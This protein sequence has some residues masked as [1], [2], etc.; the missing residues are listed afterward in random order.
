MFTAWLS[1]PTYLAILQR[2]HQRHFV[3]INALLRDLGGHPT[4]RLVGLP[5]LGADIVRIRH[6]VCLSPPPQVLPLLRSP[7]SRPRRPDYQFQRPRQRKSGPVARRVTASLLGEKAIQAR[8]NSHAAVQKYAERRISSSSVV[9][10][11]RA[12]QGG[13][14]ISKM[15][16]GCRGQRGAG[17]VGGVDGCLSWK[18]SRHAIAGRGGQRF[19][20]DWYPPSAW[21]AAPAARTGVRAEARLWG[22]EGRRCLTA[23][24]PFSPCERATPTAGLF[25]GGDC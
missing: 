10:T 4:L 9:W 23:L 17:V 1:Q 6:L 24:R 8:K 2:K 16:R 12:G 19:V 11:Q 18:C 25:H 15:Q 13:G 22:R 21:P 3:S 7:S 14:R 5:G 20:R